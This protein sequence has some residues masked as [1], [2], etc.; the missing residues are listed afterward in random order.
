M[1][2]LSGINVL[3]AESIGEESSNLLELKNYLSFSDIEI[4]SAEDYITI[5]IEEANTILSSAGKP[6]L[7]VYTQSYKFPVGTIIK[8]IICTPINTKNTKLNEKIKPAPKPMPRINLQNTKIENG[9]I[10]EIETNEVI[11]EFE[12]IIKEDEEIYSNSELFPNSWFNYKIGRGL[13]ENE[14]TI[15]IK[16]DSY[17]IRYSPMNNIIQTA[18]SFDIKIIYEK[19]QTFPVDSDENYDLLIITPQKFNLQLQ[20]LKRHKEKMGVSTIITTTEEIYENFDGMDKPEQIKYYVK[21]AKENYNIKYLLL[22]GG[23]KNHLT[24]ND[25]D[26]INEGSSAWYIPVRYANLWYISWDF[27][28]RGI[29]S[30]LYYA[31]IYRVNESSGHY[32]EF[33]DWN[34]DGDDIIANGYTIDY[35]K[36][37]LYPDVYYGR[38]ACRNHREVRNVINKIIRY[39]SW[40]HWNQ[41]WFRKMIVNGGMTFWWHENQPDGEWLCN[42][43]LDYMGDVIENPV[44]VFASNEKRPRPIPRDIGW[45]MTKGAGFALFQ[46]HGAPWIWDTYWF[47]DETEE[48][49]EWTGGLPVYQYWRMLNGRRLPIVVVGGCHNGLFNVTFLKTLSDLGKEGHN[50]SYFTYGLPIR[51]CFSWKMVSRKNGGAIA[52]TGCTGFGLGAGHPL[53]LSAELESNFF[54]KIGQDGLTNVGDAHSGSIIK[55]LEDNPIPLDFSDV[56]VIAIYEFFGDPSLRIGGY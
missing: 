32:D 48:D 53:S 15:F 22:V 28:E 6:M 8:D 10:E 45:E 36:M 43:S 26:N 47:T 24:A 37:D 40:N 18:E 39:E 46:G 27:S 14:D 42:L 2:V 56:Y 11:N 5:E 17:P 25:R 41:S 55:Y 4:R 19:T 52:C 33:D 29:P 49:L 50:I 31:D 20:R 23:L 51:E 12:E 13:Y 38:L 35:E 9:I 54:Y 7:P 1:L 21:Y 16:I 34:Y 3:N 30:D 44:R